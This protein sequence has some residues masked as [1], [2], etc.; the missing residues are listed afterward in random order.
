M[1]VKLTALLSLFGEVLILNWIKC[2]GGSIPTNA[3]EAG[4]VSA[5]RS[6][7]IARH[8]KDQF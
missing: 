1:S 6:V 5:G 2:N 3:F 8:V 7:Y 4:Y